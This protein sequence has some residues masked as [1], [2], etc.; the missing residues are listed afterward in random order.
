MGNFDIYFDK[1]NNIRDEFKDCRWLRYLTDTDN[2]YVNAERVTSINSISGRELIEYVMRTLDI[3]D[4]MELDAHSKFI[5]NEVLNWSEVAKGGLAKERNE[6]ISKGYPLD[7]HNLA[8]AEIYMDY[9][10]DKGLKSEDTELIYALIKTHGLIGQCIRG[11]VPVSH[12]KELFDIVNEKLNGN[13]SSSSF[14]SLLT[15]LNEC[16]IKA[17]SLDIWKAVE[18]DVKTLI[19]R[20]LSG[21]LSEFSAKYRLEK[22]CPKEIEIFDDSSDFFENRIFPEYELWYFTSALSD[23]D[24]G[25]IRKV[26]DLILQDFDSKCFKKSDISHINFKPLADSLYY[27]Y[28][29]KKHVNVYKKRIIEKYLL[30]SSVQNVQIDI[31]IQNRTA[32]VDFRFSKVCEKLID[33]CVEAERSG[34]L[35][36]EKSIVVLYDMFGFRKDAFDRLNNEAKYLSTMNN[37]AGSTKDSIIEYAVGKKIVDVG[38]GGGILLDRLE[39]RYPDKEIIG[40]DISQNVIETLEQK[41]SKEGHKWTV[42]IQNFAESAFDEKVDSIIFS[43]IL[44]EIYSYT[45]GE[46]GRFD[47]ES[48]KKALKYAFDSLNPGGRIIIRDGIKTDSNDI[49]RIAFKDIRGLD[50][51]HNYQRDFKGL[52]DIPDEKKVINVDEENLEVTGDINFIREFMYTYT[53]GNESYP[54]EVQEQFGYFTLKEYVDYLE[55]LGADIITAREFLEPGYPSNLEQ[56]LTLL[57]K[58]G[59]EVAYPESNCIIVLEKR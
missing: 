42:K 41:K 50:F 27:D 23:F 21:D 3:L 52:K 58:D 11:E 45:E 55:S 28:E 59:N 47:I 29:S 44:H 30:D 12:N 13:D 31:K 39:S 10:S 40:T 48:V 26:F 20:I 5:I 46:N 1:D 17:V 18:T 35:T 19:H 38:S 16:I 34:L 56:Y 22:L 37:V 33:F 8:S 9:I 6:W 7:I 32:Y 15:A 57:D 49:R 2:I 43:S 53:W 4:D 14:E 51:F 25:Q 24:M 54:H 36:F